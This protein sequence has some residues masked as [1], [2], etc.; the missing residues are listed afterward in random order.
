MN[1]PDSN[2]TW[3]GVLAGEAPLTW[4]LWA[5]DIE[6]STVLTPTGQ[7][8][9]LDAVAEIAEFL[10]PDWLEVHRWHVQANLVEMPFISHRWWPANDTAHVMLR[11]LEFALRLRLLALAKARRLDTVRRNTR[12]DLGHFAHSY[13]QLEVAALALRAGW[14]VHLEPPPAVAGG[15]KVDLLITR[16]GDEMAVEVK[17][18][19]MDGL[20]RAD[21]GTTDCIYRRLLWLSVERQ[22][23]FDGDLGVVDTADQ[24]AMLLAWLDSLD[25]IAATVQTTGSALVIDTPSGG[26][27]RVVPEASA[28]PWQLRMPVRSKDP[29]RKLLSEI[30]IKAEQGRGGSPLWLRFNETRW[31]FNQVISRDERKR[32]ST[33]N[34]LVRILERNLALYPHVAGLVLSSEPISISDHAVNERVRLPGTATAV[35]RTTQHPWYRSTMVVGGPALVA[36]RQHRGEWLSWYQGEGD[37]LDW[38]LTQSG[39]PSVSGLIA[40]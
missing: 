19:N 24:Q 17:T 14:V 16:A 18:F 20:M 11:I 6:T 8:V 39:L 4:D 13:V 28:G 31:F 33:R 38:A 3:R 23:Q 30:G 35:V 27:V 37:W 21:L 7:R 9:L 15:S 29:L 1:N 26:R 36:A 32:V 5:R 10:G 40:S 25:A 12:G 34:N 22:V 2:E